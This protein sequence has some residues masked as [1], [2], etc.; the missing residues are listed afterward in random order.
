MSVLDILLAADVERGDNSDAG[1]TEGGAIVVS[2]VPEDR[3]GVGAPQQA[4]H[5]LQ[6]C[7]CRG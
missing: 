4:V 2:G 6:V 7:L 5:C 3:S 1:E